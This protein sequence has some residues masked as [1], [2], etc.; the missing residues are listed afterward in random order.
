MK[1]QYIGK[2]PMG[3]LTLLHTPWLQE[4]TGMSCNTHNY[5]S[6]RSKMG[7]TMHVAQPG[8]LNIRS[9]TGKTHNA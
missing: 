6:L 3:F 5:R 8:P 4:G 2:K 1:T 9:L 7:L